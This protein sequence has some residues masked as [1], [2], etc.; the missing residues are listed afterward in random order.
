MLL[1]ISNAL[2]F[3]QLRKITLQRACS[4]STAKLKYQSVINII[5]TLNPKH[6]VPA[7]KKKTNSIPAKNQDTT[8][9]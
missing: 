6:T 3:F 7:P 1:S 9:Q 5:I 8:E 4:Q 2:C